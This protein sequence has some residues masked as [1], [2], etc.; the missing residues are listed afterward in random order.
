MGQVSVLDK[1][2]FLQRTSGILLSFSLFEW[3]CCY[4]GINMVF[5]IYANLNEQLN[6]A[7]W[8]DELYNSA[9]GVC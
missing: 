6:E 5:R 7:G 3:K 2:A 8:V 4:G 9:K 1:L